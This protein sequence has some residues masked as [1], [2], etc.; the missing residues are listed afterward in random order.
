MQSLVQEIQTQHTP[1]TLAESLRGEPGLVLLR[2]GAF[3]HPGARYSFVCVHPFLRFRAFG[4]ECHLEGAESKVLFGNPWN[5]L[6]GLMARFELLDEIDL[7][8]PLGGC[9]GYW[10]YDLKNFVEP[11]LPRRAFNDLELPDLCVGFYTSVIVFDHRLDRVWIVATGLNPDGSRDFSTAR[12][13][14][15]FWNDIL[16]EVGRRV[17]TPPPPTNANDLSSNLSRQ[18]YIHKINI[19]Q[20]FIRA[21]DIYQVNIAQRFAANTGMDGWEFFQRLSELSPAPYAAYLDCGD[22]Q[23]ASSSPELFLRISGDG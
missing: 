22:F 1:D 16:S 19:A 23:I 9:C 15:A 10:G 20:D 3:G 11:K 2:S 17:L 13:Q 18:E 6:E 5:V 14:L 21:G 12:N 8:F 7:P 4:S